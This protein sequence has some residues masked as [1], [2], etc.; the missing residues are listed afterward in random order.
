[1]TEAHT[2]EAAPSALAD[3]AEPTVEAP[4]AKPAKAAPKARPRPARRRSR[5]GAPAAKPRRRS[6]MTYATA[7]AY[8][9]I[10]LAGV[11]GTAA[12]AIK[13]FVV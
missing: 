5:K 10:A 9:C 13:V 7:F 3:A 4:E 1:M 12:V 11:L 8:A 6:A 2:P